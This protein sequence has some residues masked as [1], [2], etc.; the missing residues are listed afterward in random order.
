MRATSDSV[1]SARIEG[2]SGPGVRF[3]ADQQLT[4]PVDEVI[5]TAPSSLRLTR[6][7]IAGRGALSP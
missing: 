2:R 7:L 4:I 3:F 1:N 6:Q 5:A